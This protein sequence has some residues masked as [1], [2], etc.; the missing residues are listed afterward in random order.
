[1][2]PVLLPTSTAARVRLS[3]LGPGGRPF[4]GLRPLDALLAL[5]AM[6][7]G[8]LLLLSD[9]APG[10]LERLSRRIDVDSRVAQV[11]ADTRSQSDFEIHIV[12]WGL[13]TVL[14]GLAM[15]SNRS[16]LAAA[17]TVL[18]VSGVAERAQGVLTDRRAMQ[19]ADLAGNVIGVCAGF[20]LVSGLSI[21]IGWQDRPPP[22]HAERFS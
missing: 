14:V 9:R 16:L 15:W 11:A 3:P 13:V 1:M 21:L 12:L 6:L 17:V 7:A 19:V 4:A 8:G 18:V 22:E 2:A 10:L 20:G 5:G